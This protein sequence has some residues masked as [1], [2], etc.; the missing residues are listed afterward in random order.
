MA[1]AVIRAGFVLAK[2]HATSPSL[3]LPSIEHPVYDPPSAARVELGRQLFFDRRLSVNSTTSGAICNVSEQGLHQPPPTNRRRRR[4][5]RHLAQ[6]L[7]LIN[8]ACIRELLHDGRDT[9]LDIQYLA[10]LLGIDEMGNRRQVKWCS[11]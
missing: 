5:S 7:T 3:G 10:P 1:R 6:R 8:V 4:R 9:S 11:D 2:Q